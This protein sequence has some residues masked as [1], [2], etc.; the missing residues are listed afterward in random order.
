MSKQSSKEELDLRI[1][2]K[3][4][5]LYTMVYVRLMTYPSL[6][7]AKVEGAMGSP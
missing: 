7:Q 6:I 3:P 4:F 1:I 5:V 2:K